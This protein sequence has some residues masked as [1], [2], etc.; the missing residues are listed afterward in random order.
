MDS[1]E[2]GAVTD[3][4]TVQKNGDQSMG[5]D[6]ARLAEMGMIREANFWRSIVD[7]A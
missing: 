6:E 7:N 5:A 3:V 2:K 1:T 4:S